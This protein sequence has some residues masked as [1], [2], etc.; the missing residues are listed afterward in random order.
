[1][2]NELKRKRKLNFKLFNLKKWQKKV[3]AEHLSNRFNEIA[4]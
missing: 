2:E 4:I 3:I 1:M